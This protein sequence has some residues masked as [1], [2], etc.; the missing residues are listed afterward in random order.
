VDRTAGVG[1]DGGMTD[2]EAFIEAIAAEPADDTPRLAFA[3]WLD[4][5]GEGARAEF[6]RLQCELNQPVP[7]GGPPRPE[8]MYRRCGELF[9]ANWQHWLLP[10]FRGLGA[11]E[12]S[13]PDGAPYFPPARPGTLLGSSVMVSR[14]HPYQPTPVEARV[15]FLDW[16]YVTRGFATA[17]NIRTQHQPRP[18]SFTTALRLE[19]ID[20]LQLAIS[21]GDPRAGGLLEPILERIRALS[22]S[23]E[24]LDD[25]ATPRTIAGLLDSPVWAGVRDFALLCPRGFQVCPARWAAEVFRCGWVR[26]LTSLG[27]ALDDEGFRL[28]LTSPASGNLRSLS[29]YGSRLSVEAARS[30]V[31]LRCRPHLKELGL[32]SSELG[33]DHVTALAAIPGWDALE[34]LDLGFNPIIGDDGALALAQ[35]PLMRNLRRLR[36]S[37]TG[38][39]ELG[40]A[41][42]ADA[43]DPLV[44]ENLEFNY[45][46]VES[47]FRQAMF[48]RF[49]NKIDLIEND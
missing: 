30:L 33:P 5:H 8:Q 7:P 42:L 10:V 22:V 20:S 48:E 12:P 1:D 46:W 36:M 9:A 19:P 43:V 23:P 25:S 40:I 18:C 38:L 49:G 28:L 16:I 13:P 15:Y 27:V 44:V 32:S 35:S 41:A 2:R 47:D 3:D 45:H 34:E 11:D 14:S 26:N 29:L 31:G 4:E 21:A 6:V 39:T 17:L 37:D 24:G